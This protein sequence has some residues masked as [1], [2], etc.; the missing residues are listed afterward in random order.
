MNDYDWFKI[1]NLNTMI[2]KIK[3]IR[4]S[5]ER[6]DEVKEMLKSWGGVETELPLNKYDNKNML[7]F[8]H[9]IHHEIVSCVVGAFMLDFINYEIIELPEKKKESLL[10]PFEKVL[11]RDYEDSKWICDMFSHYRTEEY[12]Y[13]CIGAS[14]KYCIPYEGNEE[15][16]G[17]TN[18]LKGGGK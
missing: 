6:P 15:L 9:P 4:G 18:E 14:W 7:F 17:T 5:K 2:E 3:M 16:V 13:G 12:R 11:V 10:K 1:K 8:V